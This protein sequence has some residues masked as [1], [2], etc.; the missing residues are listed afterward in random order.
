MAEDNKKDLDKERSEMVRKQVE[1]QLAG[2]MKK[3]EEQLWMKRIEIAKKGILHFEKGEYADAIKNYLMYL[4][5]LEAHKKVSKGALS[6]AIFDKLKDVHE[7]L[8]IAGIYWDLAK[9][10]DHSRTRASTIEMKNFLN[11]FVEFSKGM[12]FEVLSA[13]NLRKY[14]SHGKA[15]HASAFRDAYRKIT[16]SKCF[17]ATSLI[18]HLAV[19]DL[20]SLRLWRDKVLQSRRDGKIFIFV[21]EKVGPSAAFVMDRLPDE[22]RKGFA[23]ALLVFLKFLK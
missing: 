5:T 15:K 12:P 13:E 20:E 23:S 21:Y 10:F 17:V 6:P 18:E 1:R 16:G 9:V 22:I 7:L 14:L 19:S 3:R 4:R 2:Q 11:K 8:L